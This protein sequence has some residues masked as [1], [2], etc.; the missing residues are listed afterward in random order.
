M[1][2][3]WKQY[4]DDLQKQLDRLT[5]AGEKPVDVELA[6]LKGTSERLGELL[7]GGRTKEIADLINSNLVGVF[8]VADGPQLQYANDR[9]HQI[10]GSNAEI[11]A[12]LA[13]DNEVFYLADQVTPCGD[14]LPWLRAL[15]GRSVEADLIFVSPT[16]KS[17]DKWINVCALPQRKHRDDAVTAA[18][19]LVVDTTDQV[20]AEHRLMQVRQALQQRIAAVSGAADAFSLLMA[21]LTVPSFAET[22]AV[23]LPVE[24]LDKDNNGRPAAGSK[25]A[26]V[27]A[28]LQINQ[29]LLSSQLS[30]LGFVAHAANNGKEAVDAAAK[31]E[32]DIILMDCDMPMMDGYSATRAIRAAESQGRRR[33]PIVAITANNRK[34]DRE[35]CLDAGMDDYIE[36][37]W[38]LRLLDKTIGIV[39]QEKLSWGDKAPN[40]RSGEADH[41]HISPAPELSQL[42]VLE[43]LYDQEELYDLMRLFVATAANSLDCLQAA[44]ADRNARA[45]HHFAYCLK[46]P[47]ALLA[48]GAI[49][50]VCR[51]IGES[52]IRGKWFDAEDKL[53]D[54]RSAFE[55][56]SSELRIG[57]SGGAGPEKKRERKRTAALSLNVLEQR[58]G[59][60]A[61]L[62]M[63]R[64]FIQDTTDIPRKG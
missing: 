37:G 51:E 54:L 35:K 10:L 18:I 30:K 38:D 29:V 11:K 32:Y 63:S 45:T 12:V 60:E 52:A 64:S 36:K 7:R 20:R 44:A 9:A 25:Q 16:S 50:E 39:M 55:S 8:I 47:A 57:T 2:T 46:G 43:G 31:N 17:G 26:G 59:K 62:T 40:M 49:A 27:V 24:R 5:D 3:E 4:V 61:A 48:L 14:H 13:S 34:G 1:E 42:K 56:L 19:V 41:D 28:D 6:L 21:K 58:V 15:D 22:S 53:A 33:T 23:A